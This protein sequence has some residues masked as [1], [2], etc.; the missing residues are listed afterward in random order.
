MS[1][2][3]GYLPGINPN[4]T[5]KILQ[6]DDDR[7]FALDSGRFVNGLGQEVKTMKEAVAANDKIDAEYNKAWPP[8]KAINAKPVRAIKS[9]PGI[10]KK[11]KKDSEGYA[12][13]GPF[14]STLNKIIDYAPNKVA[15][16]KQKRITPSNSYQILKK[17]E[18]E[19]PNR[20]IDASL[21]FNT[22]VDTFLAERDALKISI[23]ES[24]KQEQDYRKKVAK[25]NDDDFNKG[26]GSIVGVIDA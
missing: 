12:K 25:R 21:F 9:V 6:D 13:P 26:L 10:N 8:Q 14:E 16:P 11:P 23:E 24:K 19:T 4:Y 5:K 1:N 20:S 15:R 18:A 3:K 2:Y 17:Q 7:Y 22:P